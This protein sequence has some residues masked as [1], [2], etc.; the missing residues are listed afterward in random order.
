[1]AKQPDRIRK[2]APVEYVAIAGVLAVFAFGTIL[3]V[4]RDAALASIGMG[5][6]FV[7]VIMVIAMLLL[8]MKPNRVPEGQRD[9]PESGND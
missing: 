1:M 2:M 7:V 4:S 9:K 5:A 3:M 8:A 6:T